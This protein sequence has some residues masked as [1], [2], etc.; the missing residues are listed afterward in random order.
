V[1][2]GV[3]IQ[4]R[5]VNQKIKN[6]GGNIKVWSCV[7]YEGV[8]YIHHIVDNLTA[9]G[10]VNILKNDLEKTI[11]YYKLKKSDLIFMHDNDPKHKA[12]KSVDYLGKQ[13]Y[14]VMEWPANSPDLNPIENL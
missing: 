6:N 7:T 5:N 4:P 2:D 9:D 8:G 11:R 12:K 3:P 1:R 10:Y 14:E 13:K